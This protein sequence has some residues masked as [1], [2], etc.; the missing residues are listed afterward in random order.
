MQKSANCS[1]KR[2]GETIQKKKFLKVDEAVAAADSQNK[3]VSNIHLFTAYK[4]TTCFFFHIGK[5]HKLNPNNNLHEQ[6]NTSNP[7]S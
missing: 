3:K 5:S 1:Y 7:S 6:K 2:N 4:C